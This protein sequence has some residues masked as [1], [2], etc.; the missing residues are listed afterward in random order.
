MH[1]DGQPSIYVL[2]SSELHEF[3]TCCAKF[4]D[5][6]FPYEDVFKIYKIS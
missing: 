4:P 5:N 6:I 1:R 2:G 3:C